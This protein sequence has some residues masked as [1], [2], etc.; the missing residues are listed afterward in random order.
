MLEKVKDCNLEIQK[1]ADEIIREHILL[2][3]S[4]LLLEKSENLVT[5]MDFLG[6]ALEKHIRKEERVL[7]P[8]MEKYV[9]EE[10]IGDIAHLIA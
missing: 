2:T 5:D 8:L 6:D 7:F 1:L 4:F 3:T 9:P 10:L